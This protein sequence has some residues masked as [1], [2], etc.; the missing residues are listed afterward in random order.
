MPNIELPDFK[1][2]QS[3]IPTVRLRSLSFEKFKVFEDYRFDFSSGDECK[4]FSCFFGPNGS[5][6]TTILDSIQI[7]FSRYD[8]Y[9]ESRLKVLLG[10]SV[11]HIDGVQ[12]G[13]YG[14]DDFLITA[15][16]QSSI[17]DYEVQLNKSGFIKDH[18][19]EVKGIVYRICFYARFDQELRQFQLPR[20]KWG[21]FKEL[22]EAVTGFEIEEKKS[23]FDESSDPVQAEMLSRYVLNF[24]VH[25]DNEIISR[26]E[27][28]AGERK[29]IKSFSTLLNK[30]Y[31]P[32]II[33]V[34]N[35]A[36]HV[37]S[38]RHL[39]LIS[40]MKRC[41]PDSQIFSTTHSYRLS[42][43]F[44]HKDQLY[45][46]RL[47]SNPDMNSGRLELMDELEDNILKLK[48]FVVYNKVVN[49]EIEIGEDLIKKC[50]DPF[51]NSFTLLERSE[52]F[53]KRTVHMHMRD[54]N[55]T[56][57]HQ[58]KCSKKNEIKNE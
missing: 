47:I 6:K 36:M 15:N 45:D 41:F 31:P 20:S 51:F 40:S 21:I 17:G 3:D 16:I 33:L 24:F 46:L 29:I 37:E 10:K 35:V 14:D 9:E 52:E 18:P 43:N 27:C 55:N 42:R 58:T 26:E 2:D 54:I 5:G 12:K 23:L 53:F 19:D 50:C 8:H 56:L 57:Q 4:P 25:K 32:Q 44:G 49:R 13:I 22:F 30:E 11:R 28:S 48:S 34:D 38:G 1:I 39:N 7:L